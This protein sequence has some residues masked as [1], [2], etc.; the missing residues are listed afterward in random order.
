MCSESS[1]M[2]LMSGHR[3]KHQQGVVIVALIRLSGI[4][5]QLMLES[6]SLPSQKAHTS[7]SGTEKNLRGDWGTERM[8]PAVNR[9]YR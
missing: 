5:S 8:V 3:K 1:D 2:C 9:Y 6:Q 4:F 7:N